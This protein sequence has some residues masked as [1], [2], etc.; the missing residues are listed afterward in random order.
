MIDDV[1]PWSHANHAIEMMAVAHGRATQARHNR[2]LR[3][4]KAL[5][6]VAGQRQR[7]RQRQDDVADIVG[8]ADLPLPECALVL[9]RH[10][11]RAQ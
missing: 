6:E 10:I 5:P 8:E 3:L 1:L 11:L 2:S 9:H 4:R 7:Q